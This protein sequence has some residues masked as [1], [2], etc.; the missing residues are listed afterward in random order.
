[1]QYTIVHVHMIDCHQ[2]CNLD[3]ALVE[4][5]ATLL[6][7]TQVSDGMDPIIAHHTGEEGMDVM[8]AA[9]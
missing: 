8:C 7:E 5:M 1:M 9:T 4:T 6:V 3:Q 2:Q